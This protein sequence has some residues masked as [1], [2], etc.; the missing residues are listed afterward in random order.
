MFIV[1]ESD[2]DV[3]SDDNNIEILNK[4]KSRKSLNRRKSNKA[5][6]VKRKRDEN[7]D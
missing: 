7:I 5:R 1:I 6:K 4:N 3:E 2:D